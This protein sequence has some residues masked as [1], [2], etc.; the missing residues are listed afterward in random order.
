MNLQYDSYNA[1]RMPL[2]LLLDSSIYYLL[3]WMG[4]FFN[5]S[6]QSWWVDEERMKETPTEREKEES[7]ARAGGSVAFAF[8]NLIWWDLLVTI[9]VY[10]SVVL[11]AITQTTGHIFKEREWERGCKGCEHKFHWMK[12]VN[13]PSLQNHTHSFWQFVWQTVQLTSVAGQWESDRWM[14]CGYVQ[15]DN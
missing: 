15:P 3:D 6:N 14:I 11:W 5:I 12:L 8:P 2:G 1:L 7:R 9:N 4:F 10:S 13:M